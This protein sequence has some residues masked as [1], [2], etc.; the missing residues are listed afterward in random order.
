MTEKQQE[1]NVI[2]EIGV[3]CEINL[4]QNFFWE[5]IHKFSTKTIGVY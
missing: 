3:F 1:P 4:E 2:K 5:Q